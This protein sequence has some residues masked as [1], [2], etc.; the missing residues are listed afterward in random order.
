L[1]RLLPRRCVIPL[2]VAAATLFTQPTSTIERLRREAVRMPGVLHE[3]PLEL[4]RRNPLLAAALVSAAGIDIPAEATAEQADSNLTSCLPT[5]L[6]ADAVTV[7]KAQGVKLA[8]VTEVQRASPKKAKRRAWPAYVA[9][10]SVEH[11]CEAVLIVIASSRAVARACAR[12]VLTGHPGFDLVPVVIGPDFAPADAAPGL[13]EAELLVLSVLTKAL[14]LS[15]RDT[16]VTVLQTIA[17]LD[18][19]RR[20]TY[21]RLVRIAASPP[22]RRALEELMTTVFKDD[23]VDGLLAEGKAEG[24]AEGQAQGEAR[25]LLRVLAA[26][27][28]QVPDDVRQR[29]L[30]CADQSQLAVWGERAATATGLEDLFS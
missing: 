8:V 23:F 17:R 1:A 21:T 18:E 20:A 3:A 7:I 16:Q 30:S 24:L 26:R 5:E 15:Q 29:I 25:M 19:H 4:L 9:L 10:A 14:D 13:A 6:R 12:P 2:S 28:L 27:G 11:Q 22:E